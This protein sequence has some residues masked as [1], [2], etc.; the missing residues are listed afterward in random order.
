MD[1]TIRNIRE[2]E[3]KILSD[4]LYEAIFIPEGVKAPPK[5][6]IN[7]PELQV[8]ISDFGKHSG[9]YCLVA[10]SD[11]KIVGA[12]WV[13]IMNDYGHID[14]ETPS[15]AISLLKEYRNYGIGTELMKQMLTKLK[16]EGYK[17]ASL[18]VQKMNYAVR[19]Y[20]KIGFEII[21][22]NDEEYIMI[23]KL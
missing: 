22:E 17:Q 14:N 20:R 10:E 19:M 3:Y 4:F 12:V 18:S 6:I 15:F 9:D 23:C 11:K 1:Y 16:L 21:D 2:T 13:R 5:D 8:Y 7:K